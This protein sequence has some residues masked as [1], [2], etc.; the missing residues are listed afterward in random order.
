MSAEENN[1]VQNGDVKKDDDLRE[2]GAETS[3]KETEPKSTE[4]QKHQNGDVR[5]RKTGKAANK[6]KNDLKKSIVKTK[7]S[8]RKDQHK[9]AFASKWLS[10]VNAAAIAINK[11]HGLV[12]LL[13]FCSVVGLALATRIFNVS[14][15]Q[16]IW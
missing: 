11:K 5:N 16:H 3:E 13:L 7:P 9:T 14:L 4:G 2:N 6:T 10:V 15:P 12:K 1:G 8:S